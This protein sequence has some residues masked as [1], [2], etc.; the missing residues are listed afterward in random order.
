[1]RM[2]SRR[3]AA[4]MLCGLAAAGCDR[5]DARVPEE[6]KIVAG[7]DPRE[8]PATMRRYGCE[9]CH[10]TPGVRG[11]DSRVGPPLTGFAR[12]RFIGGRVPNEPENLL[13]WIRNPQAV[14]PGNAMPNL[15]VTAQDAE[16]IAAYL[17]RLR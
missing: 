6:E 11:A 4:A 12:R 14:K 10:T 7:G 1:M 8:G 2:I 15:G 13:L 17:Y 9:A 3:V 16:D 5:L